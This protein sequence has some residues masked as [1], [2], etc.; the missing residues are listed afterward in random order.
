MEVRYPPAMYTSSP[1]VLPLCTNSAP[2]PT[3]SLKPKIEAKEP[4]R[5][6]LIGASCQNRHAMSMFFGYK[7]LL[8]RVS[9]EADK[10]PSTLKSTVARRAPEDGS[11]ASNNLV[12]FTLISLEHGPS[13]E[14]DSPEAW[15][16]FQDTFP[17]GTSLLES[18]SVV[19]IVGFV[20]DTSQPLPASL[21]LNSVLKS[22]LVDEN[23]RFCLLKFDSAKDQ[24]RGRRNSEENRQNRKKLFAEYTSSCAERI[25]LKARAELNKAVLQAFPEQEPEQVKRFIIPEENSSI[26]WHDTN[27]EVAEFLQETWEQAPVRPEKRVRHD[28]ITPAALISGKWHSAT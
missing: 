28:L 19:D 11:N 27:Q 9:L 21:V 1:C 12:P 17:H 7:Q 3:T 15:V 26:A 25:S 23:T 18:E 8:E 10:C 5:I 4:V 22:S 14:L 16:C 2:Q 13:L 6:L 24:D 20:T